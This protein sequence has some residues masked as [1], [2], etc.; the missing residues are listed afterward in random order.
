[1]NTQI[2]ELLKRPIFFE[3]NR[4]FRVYKGGLLFNGLFNDAP[5]DGNLPEEWIASTVKALN[6]ISAGPK[7]GISKV[8][9]TDIYLDD[10]IELYKNEILGN[11]ED[12]GILV[13]VLDSAVR[14]PVQVHPDKTFSQEY[15]KSSY[16]KAEAWIVL[17]TRPGS[18]IYF[19]FKAHT[20]MED[21]Y[22]AVDQ[23]MS[24]KQAME[25]LIVRHV[26]KKDDVFFI[27]ARAVHA[28][29]YGCLILEVQEPTDFTIQ[30]E[31]WCDDYKLSDYEKYMGLDKGIA[32]GCF[33][34]SISGNNA[35]DISRVKPKDISE[36]VTVKIESLID[37]RY[38]DCFRVNRISINSDSIVL[39]QG[40]AIYVVTQGDGF[41]SCGHGSKLIKKGDY[42]MLPHCL[43]DKC[44]V[45]SKDKI[46]LVECFK[47]TSGI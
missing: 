7:E 37:K 4:V 29:G 32:L 33:D 13:K 23:S 8:R 3:R 31:A 11:Q 12:I 38:T 46:S 25:K 17:D 30:P 18:C 24:D 47:G 34:M 15:F 22:Q 41:I 6:K 2:K 27:P 45:S 36:K 21:L 43:K 28:I 14:L 40:P 39:K 1:M 9:D 44:I 19:G 10:L 35:I 26:V 20:T 5:E 16:G 42:F